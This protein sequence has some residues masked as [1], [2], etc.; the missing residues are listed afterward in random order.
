MI[1]MSAPFQDSTE[2][3]GLSGRML[4]EAAFLISPLSID[5]YIV[6]S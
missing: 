4:S 1:M 6:T 5:E 3:L 2:P